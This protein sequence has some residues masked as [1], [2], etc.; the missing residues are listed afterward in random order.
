MAGS[1]QDAM[2]G[3]IA[4]DVHDCGAYGHDQGD[5]RKCKLCLRKQLLDA[6][7][8][9][10]A[11]GMKVVKG[12]DAHQDLIRSTAQEIAL[13][14]LLEKLEVG[15]PSE[16]AIKALVDRGYLVRRADH[17]AL[18]STLRDAISWLRYIHESAMGKALLHDVA[19]CDIC[20]FIE[21]N[22]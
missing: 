7:R 5:P 12:G 6:C 8:V 19:Y 14:V 17:E 4:V 3:P 18:N 1:E 16:T 20:Q 2:T 21:R 9:V 15:E 13:E 10:N 11:A 22:S